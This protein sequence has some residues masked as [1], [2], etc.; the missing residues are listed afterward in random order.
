V[1]R[2]VLA[3]VAL[4]VAV[5]LGFGAQAAAAPGGSTDDGTDL[6]GAPDGIP[7]GIFPVAV[8]RTLGPSGG[9]LRGAL[10]T[11]TVTL[12]VPAGTFATAVQV[13]IVQPPASG[14]NAVAAFGLRVNKD[15]RPVTG[16][17]ARSVRI[18][19]TGSALL[20][21]NAAIYTPEGAGTRHLPFSRTGQ[22][23]TVT[24]AGPVDRVTVLAPAAD[25][26]QT[27]TAKDTSLLGSVVRSAGDG[28]TLRALLVSLGLLV[29]FA[30]ILTLGFRRR[31]KPV[32][33]VTLPAIGRIRTEPIEDP[34]VALKPL[35]DQTVALPRQRSFDW[36]GDRSEKREKSPAMARD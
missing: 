1:V 23:V 16:S 30:A 32:D 11:G 8:S 36:W 28:V 15:G 24:L 6:S 12:T 31:A 22:N 26:P 4:V 29:V 20:S 17:F 33:A 35:H 21:A 2:R 27:A 7:G 25:A 3:A 13:T 19:L 34:T 5:L 10:G 18:R 14:T 9:V